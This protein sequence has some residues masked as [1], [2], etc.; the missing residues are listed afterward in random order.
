MMSVTG[1]IQTLW[2]D[3]PIQTKN[4][5]ELVAHTKV[6]KKKIQYSEK[7]LRSAFIEFYRGLG[8]LR[9]FR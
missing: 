7:M 4:E 5:H 8:L 2:E 6:D 1:L 9:T 3:M